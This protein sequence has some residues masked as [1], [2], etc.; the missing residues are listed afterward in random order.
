M[1]T[2]KNKPVVVREY[3]DTI[4]PPWDKNHTTNICPPDYI[5]ERALAT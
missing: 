4:V 5:E 3:Q 1:T 2:S